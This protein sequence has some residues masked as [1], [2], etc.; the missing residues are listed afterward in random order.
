[1]FPKLIQ[2]IPLLC[3]VKPKHCIYNIKL[4]ESPHR[5]WK[6]RMFGNFAQRINYTGQHQIYRLSF[7]S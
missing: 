7:F 2:R 5:S 3:E 6:Q 4:T 1:M